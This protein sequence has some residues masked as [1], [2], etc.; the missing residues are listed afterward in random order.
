MKARNLKDLTFGHFFSFLRHKQIQKIVFYDIFNEFMKMNKTQNFHMKCYR[1]MWP[2][3][4]PVNAF[5]RYDNRMSKF[6]STSM[7]EFGVGG[8]VFSFT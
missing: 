1:C 8:A 4:C 2:I 3:C 7:H 5:R 6:G